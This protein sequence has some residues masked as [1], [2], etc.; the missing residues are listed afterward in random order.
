MEEVR[1]CA[2]CG[3]E[4]ALGTGTELVVCDAECAQSYAEELYEQH[5]I[6]EMEEEQAR[7]LALL[8]EKARE[9]ELVCSGMGG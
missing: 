7:E 5:R 6:L 4:V 9:W 3:S 2:G 8:D 1:R